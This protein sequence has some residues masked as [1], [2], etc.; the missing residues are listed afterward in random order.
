MPRN[1]AGTYS[2]PG[3]YN[4]VATNDLITADWANNTL[5][6]I[7]AA[8]TLS[9]ARDGSGGMLA[10]FP[11]ADGTL[12]SPGI[13]FANENSTGIARLQSSSFSI[14]VT[15][16][17]SV[18]V[19]ADGVT[20]YTRPSTSL[21]PTSGTHLVNKT[22]TD[23]TFAALLNP[24]FNPLGFPKWAGTPAAAEDLANK[25]YVDD[26]GFSAAL[27]GLSGAELGAIVRKNDSGNA[28]WS[29]EDLDLYSLSVLSFLGA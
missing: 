4:P 10:S 29:T 20:F 26:T 27:P 11:L 1:A 17:E 18:R 22:Y 21:V 8:L 9:L 2:L 24:V 3:A 5:N 16:V 15:A 13:N 6:D 14:V 23:A 19:L 12:I 25:A 28:E 7:A